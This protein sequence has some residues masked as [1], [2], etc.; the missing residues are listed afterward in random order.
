MTLRLRPVTV[1]WT[2]HRSGDCC[3]IP[4]FVM[5]TAEERAVIESATDRALTW[6]VKDGWAALRAAPCPLL[7]RD[8]DGK[9]V[10]SVYDVRPYN[11]RRFACGR[12]SPETEA[13]ELADGACLN[14]ADR[15]AQSKSF[16]SWARRLQRSSQVWAQA[17]GWG[18]E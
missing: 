14:M 6:M 1:P 7:D 10:C 15:V 17:H 5:M 3:T 9:A 16:R 8:E 4:P 13:F 11:C 12:V 2:C 18:S